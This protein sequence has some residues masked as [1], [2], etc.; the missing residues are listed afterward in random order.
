MRCSNMATEKKRIAVSLNKEMEKEV[1]RIA[2]EKGIAKS[3]VLVIALSE[4]L[5][6]AERN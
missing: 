6:K 4:Y 1:N 5:K 2:E 3:T